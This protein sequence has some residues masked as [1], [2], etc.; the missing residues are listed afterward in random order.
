MPRFEDAPD[1]L[2]ARIN[3]SI[4]FDRRLWREDVAGSRAHAAGARARRGDR[5]PSELAELRPRPRPWSRPSSRRGE[6]PFAAGDEDIHM[7]VE[8]RLTE[9]VGPLGGKLHTGRSRNDQVATDLAL[10][11]RER[12]ARARE[13]I[14]ALMERLLDA[15]RGPPRLA[16]ARLHPPAARPAGLPRPSPARLLL[17]AAR[18][19]RSGSPTPPRAAAA[20]PLGSGALAGLNWDLDR[21]ATAAELGFDGAGAELDRRGL[22]PR[23]RARLHVRGDRL[24]DP[25]LAARQRDRALVEP[26]VRLLPSRRRRLLLRLEPHAAEEEPGRRRA[27][28]GEVAAGRGLAD[29]ARRACC[30]P[31]R[32]PT[33]KD[34]Q[35]DKEAL[36]DAVD[37][38]ELCLEA[39]E[40]LLAGLSFD[41]ERLAAAAGDEMVAATDVADLLVRRGMPF[42]E[43]HG[44]V[45][46]LVRRRSSSGRALSEL[47][48]GG[49]RRALRAARRRVLRGPARGLVAG[50]E[51]VGRRD[52]G[53]A[54]SPSSWRPR[55]RR[56]ATTRA[57]RRLE[58]ART[59]VLRPLG[60]PA[61]PGDL[62]GCE[63]RVGGVGGVIVETESYERD[64]PACHAYVGLTRADGDPVRPARDAPTSTSPTGSTASSTPSASPTGPPPRS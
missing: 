13:L 18:A 46:G 2:F 63:L 41:R 3:A 4:G 11:V 21:E 29:D 16:D 23:L 25:P 10:Y 31:C 14:A 15:R 58:R 12:S 6:F 60:A 35:E 54:R 51:A 20:M 19:T 64:D 39:A 42:R 53:R 30:T 27:A 57:G 59:G 17:D 5:P 61:S 34:L 56:L 50:L 62:I 36:F 24:R 52:L 38:I 37:T 48:A 43:A 28:A 40:R 49:A 47:D 55:G 1:P 9:L 32:S 7:A 8:R 44:V 26:G 33:R 22:Q 45:G